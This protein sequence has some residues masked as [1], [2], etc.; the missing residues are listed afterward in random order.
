MEKL[1]TVKEAAEILRVSRATLYRHIGNG[2][3]KPIKLGGK[4]LFTES[5][6]NDLIK[7]LRRVK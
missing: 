5:G 7:K 3:I 4:V 1:Y 6:L 2:I